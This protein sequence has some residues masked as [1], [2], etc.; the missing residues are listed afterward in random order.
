MLDQLFLQILNMSF[1]ASFV[2]LFVLIARLFLKK[3]PKMF[4]Y[5]L[6]AVVLFRLICPFSFE[7][8]FSLLPTKVSPIS[9]DISKIDT[10]IPAINYTLNSSLPAATPYAST[11]SM[12]VWVFLGKVTWLVGIAILLMY[13]IVSLLKVQKRLKKA[14]HERDNIYL[15]EHLRTAFVV[16][17]IRPKV[18]LPTV[19]GDEEKQYILL[20]EQMHIQRLDHVI[21]IL[22][23]FVLCLHWFNPLVWVAF[24]S[25]GR[26]MEMSC[27]E[28]VIEQLGNDVKKNYSSSLLA[29]ATGRRIIAG[30]P[31]A[32]GEGDTKS[33]VK[34]VLNYRKPRSW[35][36]MS[37]VILVVATSIGLAVNPI[38]TTKL[39]EVV[40]FS[41]GSLDRV[42]YGTITSHDRHMDFNQAKAEEITD[43]LG[44]LKVNKS[45]VSKVRQ[46]DRDQTNQI[47][48]VFT[49][50]SDNGH[51]GNLYFNFSEDFS[52]VWVDND[53]KPSFSHTVLKPSEVKAFFQQ[54]FG[55]VTQAKEIGSATELWKART[56]YIGDN[57]A[58]GKLIGL[59]PVSE[60]LQYDHFELYT[61]YQPYMV[62]IVYSVS[63]ETLIQYDTEEANK[64]MANP[65]RK[66]ALILLALIDNADQITATLTD[67]TRTV[68]FINSREW[69]DDIV[70]GD[71]R[72]FAE[73][74]ETLQKLIDMP[75]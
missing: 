51:M 8:M 22:S 9:Q 46:L 33:R 59:L 42:T 37:A 60:N 26:D 56:K 14:V 54:Q 49:E 34:N 3:S 41:L 2:I 53:V 15:A 55:S 31:L 38:N 66:D 73:S 30:A 35:M 5:A 28:M 21:K 71:V 63:T 19:L 75:L 1:T 18:Y 7:S 43:Y 24:F 40:E 45:Q 17:V 72:T 69:A 52:E 64:T 36:I 13:S 16:G 25:S 29:L 65:F 57:S 74:A 4:S 70:G 27:D 58:V 62:K 6:W 67:G 44:E 20:H 50:P 23:F 32:F 48:F 68:G 12:Q 10:G 39:F 61:D 47:H 11:N